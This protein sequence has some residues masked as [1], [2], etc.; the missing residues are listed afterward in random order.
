GVAMWVRQLDFAVGGAAERPCVA[1]SQEQPKG[2]VEE[3]HAWGDDVD[4]DLDLDLDPV[5]VQS[6]PEPDAW[7]DDDDDI[8][9]DADLQNL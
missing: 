7:G 9:L 3:E 2:I 5:A 1:D 8:D 6:E 4:I